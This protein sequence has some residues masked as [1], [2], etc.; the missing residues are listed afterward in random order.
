METLTLDELIA[1]LT[2]L[3]EDLPHGHMPVYVATCTGWQS[4]TSLRC[5]T[6]RDSRQ[7]LIHI[8][9]DVTAQRVEPSK[10]CYGWAK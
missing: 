3:R 9:D 4:T 1:A 2:R 6:T 5:H 7:V 8:G 10:R